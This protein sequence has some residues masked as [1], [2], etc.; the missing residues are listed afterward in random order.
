MNTEERIAQA[1]NP[2]EFVRLCNTVLS[3]EYG[4][5]YQVVDG[6]RGD[7][8]ND[9]YIAS[10]ERLLAIYCPSKPESRSDKHFRG[11]ISTDLAKA[12][13]LRD[14]GAIPISRWT[15]ITPRKLSNSVLS[16]MYETAEGFGLSANHQESTY[17]SNLVS[18]HSNVLQDFPWL[19]IDDV[20]AKLSTIIEMLN[21]QRH[22]W[23][24]L[25]EARPLGA[26]SFV[27]ENATDDTREVRE[28]RSKPIDE[29]GKSRLRAI[30]YCSTDPI[31]Q[32]EAI[33]V[34]L[35]M[36]DVTKDSD[37]D[38]IALC[39]LA[40]SLAEQIPAP[41]CKAEVISCKGT[42]YSD[43]FARE[44][45]QY[46]MSAHA[47]LTIGFPVISQ[48]ESNRKRDRLESLR[49]QSNE[50][51]TVALDLAQELNDPDC[52]ARVLLNVGQSAGRRFIMFSAAGDSEQ[53]TSQQ[54]RCKQA[55]MTAK[56][57][58]AVTGQE[59][60][61][62]YALHNLANQLRF[63][64]EIE[65]AKCL[66]AEVLRLTDKHADLHLKYLAG[67]LMNCLE[68]GDTRDCSDGSGEVSDKA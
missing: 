48:D 50:H 17:L 34:L 42:L 63:F 53:A 35:A 5:H 9:G 29:E 64:G 66:T 20:D 30:V 57:L 19:H 11:K 68:G 62:A 40:V 23:P 36:Q 60:N 51:F 14:K 26:I 59:N 54:V 43:I 33:G 46:V 25:E 21:S 16:F 41:S 27:T 39:D 67:I 55:L 44:Y 2:Q 10:E 37:A 45:L 52:I 8:G 47:D 7:D 12:A 3:V 32:L 58:F 18:K 15:F 13:K 22:E 65:E 56:N 24:V 6:T 61:V 28:I 4:Q 31:A 38:M 1:N 49:K